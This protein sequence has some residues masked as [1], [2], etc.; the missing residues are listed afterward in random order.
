MITRTCLKPPPLFDAVREAFMNGSRRFICPHTG[1]AVEI[2]EADRLEEEEKS[3]CY[4]EHL[5]YRFVLNAGRMEVLLKRDLKIVGK[6]MSPSS[7]IF[8]E[9]IEA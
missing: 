9:V 2:I 8:Y 1:N 5:G 7:K 3:S 6:F 4:F